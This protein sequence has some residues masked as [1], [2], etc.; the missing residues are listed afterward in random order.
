MAT[1][2]AAARVTVDKLLADVGGLLADLTSAETPQ[3]AEIAEAEDA[4]R[5][6]DAQVSR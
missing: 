2:Y 6:I 1:G 4:R 3:D 5:V